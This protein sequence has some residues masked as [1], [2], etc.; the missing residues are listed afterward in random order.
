MA[1]KYGGRTIDGLAKKFGDGQ[2]HIIS[3]T[4]RVTTN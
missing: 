1:A 4:K 3:L 2:V